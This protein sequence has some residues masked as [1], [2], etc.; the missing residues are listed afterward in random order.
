VKQLKAHY[1][2][3][4]T[5]LS[6]EVLFRTPFPT[7]EQRGND[8]STGGGVVAKS[9]VEQADFSWTRNLDA[10]VAER[11]IHVMALCAK[12]GLKKEELVKHQCKS[13]GGLPEGESSCK[14]G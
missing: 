5:D 10:M 7:R 12:A 14:H 11:D 4:D 1:M 3:L 13:C 2:A 8:T 9:Y 6:G